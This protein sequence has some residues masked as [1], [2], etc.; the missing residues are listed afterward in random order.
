LTQDLGNLYIVMQI[1]NGCVS[2]EGLREERRKE[3]IFDF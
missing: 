1:L 2:I 3:F